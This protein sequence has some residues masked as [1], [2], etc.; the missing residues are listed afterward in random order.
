MTRARTTA[1]TLRRILDSFASDLHVALPGR[2]RSYD[3]DTQTAE[4]ELGI[5]RV[6]AADDQ[7]QDPDTTESMPVLPSVPVVWPSSGGF[8]LHWPLAAGDTV[9]V[10][11]NESDLNAWRDSDGSTVDPGVALRH[12]LSGAVAYPGLR[13]R[14]NP[15]GDADGTHGRVGRDG[16]P[17]VEFRPDEIHV[18]GP[19]QLVKAAELR[20]HLKV[21]EADLDTIATAAGTVST[22]IHDTLQGLGTD[23]RTETTKGE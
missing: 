1:E 3:A 4:I 21:I 6:R 2:I 9:Q 18:G 11:F 13:T 17:Y 5:Q 20:L 23:Y 14:G 7:E 16:G 15:I 8:F 22:Y 19:A 12:A 10:L